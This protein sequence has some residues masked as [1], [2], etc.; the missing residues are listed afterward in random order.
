MIGN[1]SI[2]SH[3]LHYS[4]WLV[5]R[6]MDWS[7][8]IASSF[9]KHY[10][11]LRFDPDHYRKE[12]I[13]GV[14]L[15]NHSRRPSIA[16]SLVDNTFIN[17]AHWNFILRFILVNWTVDLLW[18]Y[19]NSSRL[20]GSIME[21][22]VI[23]CVWED[24]WNVLG[25]ASLKGRFITEVLI[26]GR[27]LVTRWLCIALLLLLDHLYDSRVRFDWPIV[28]WFLRERDLKLHRCIK[29]LVTLIL[30]LLCMKILDRLLHSCCSWLIEP[31]LFLLALWRH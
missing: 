24:G 22:F 14:I 1:R 5:T 16:I 27:D 12:V 11:L 21:T 4:W 3:P 10:L 19:V 7:K 31:S 2:P 9:F 25:A 29:M 13:V 18:L 17:L 23:K 6:S 8:L 28:K 20:N 15:L 30:T 26:S